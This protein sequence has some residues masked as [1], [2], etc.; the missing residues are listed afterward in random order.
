ME[1]KQHTSKEHMGQRRNFKRNV[2]N[3]LN[4]IKMKTQLIKIFGIQ[5]K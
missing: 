5:T 4:E 1:I 2:Y 3:I